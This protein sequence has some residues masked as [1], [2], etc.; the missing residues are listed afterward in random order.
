M[1]KCT[2]SIRSERLA[3]GLLRVVPAPGEPPVTVDAVT[4]PLRSGDR[5]A[6]SLTFFA[7]IR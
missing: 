5:L 3:R 6:G 7:P 1:K 4:T 2:L